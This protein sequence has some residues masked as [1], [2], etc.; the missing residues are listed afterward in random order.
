M[1]ETVE[2][3]PMWC[4]F[5]AAHQFLRA[6]LTD[7]LFPHTRAVAVWVEAGEPDAWIVSLSAPELGFTR[8]ERFGPLELQQ[9]YGRWAQWARG[10]ARD[11][12]KLL[13]S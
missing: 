2:R 6:R 4:R 13:L 11:F 1:D 3:I 8:C 9:V 7:E 12:A 10:C 5:P